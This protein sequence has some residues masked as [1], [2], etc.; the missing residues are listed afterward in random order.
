MSKN[1]EKI[2]DLDELPTVDYS[3]VPQKIQEAV[4][5]TPFTIE[6]KTKLTW[7]GRQFIARIPK[8]IAVEMKISKENVLVFR[9]TKP[10]PNSKEKPVL[11]IK[12]V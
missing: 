6:E 11:V 4:A 1:D 12:L 9:F 8:E 2:K 7:D 3:E 10:L 5:Q